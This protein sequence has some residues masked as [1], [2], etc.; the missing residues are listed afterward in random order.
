MTTI[1]RNYKDFLTWVDIDKFAEACHNI[2][3]S[4]GAQILNEHS[5]RMLKEKY[6]LGALQKCN[7]GGNIQWVDAI[8]YDLI[9]DAWGETVEV[10]TGDGPIYTE[11]RG[12]AKE[13]VNVKLKNIYE[14]KANTRTTLDKTFDHLMI[15]Q[16]SGTFAV[17]FVP[18]GIVSQY[19]VSLTDGWKAKIPFDKV[20][21]V[22]AKNMREQPVTWTVDLN[23]KLWVSTKLTE[24]GL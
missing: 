5:N 21:I 12:D 23:P 3:G 8:D 22:Y 14:S 6:L 11:K 18:Y 2:S 10:K 20:E 1:T 4:V 19:L 16:N 13:F 7:H 17:G 9:F 24:A 15:I